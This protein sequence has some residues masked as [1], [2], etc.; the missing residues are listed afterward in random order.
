MG[1][2]KVA[3]VDIVIKPSHTEIYFNA[4]DGLWTQPSDIKVEID[5]ELV[6]ILELVEAYRAGK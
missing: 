4:K 2:E 3:P 6:D 1:L 5:G